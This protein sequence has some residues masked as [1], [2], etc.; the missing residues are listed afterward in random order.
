MTATPC[1]RHPRGVWMVACADCT[2]WYM[3]IAR[4]HRDE[5]VPVSATTRT[6]DRATSPLAATVVAPSALHLAA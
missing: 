3:P 1:Y 6:A 2:A 5:V 4:A